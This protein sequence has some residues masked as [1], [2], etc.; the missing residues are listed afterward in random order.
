MARVHGQNMRSACDSSAAA[1][2]RIASPRRAASSRT[3]S[4]ECVTLAHAST[5]RRAR[6]RTSSMRFTR[7]RH[8]E[9]RSTVL[10]SCAVHC[11]SSSTAATSSFGIGLSKLLGAFVMAPCPPKTSRA[12]SSNVDLAVFS[13]ASASSPA[14]VY[15]SRRWNSG[16]TAVVGLAARKWTKVITMS[17]PRNSLACPSGG[18]AGTTLHGHLATSCARHAM[19]CGSERTTTRS[20][21][22]PPVTVP[23]VRMR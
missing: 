23:V 9:Q 22:V 11:H 14:L 12:R 5:L 4:A 1:R 20:T 19:S 6:S 15:P 7:V 3:S 17:R 18:S 16:C 10:N 8:D 21:L 13:T 2:E